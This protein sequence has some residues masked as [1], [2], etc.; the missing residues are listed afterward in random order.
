ML[1]QH[2]V[3]PSKNFHNHEFVSS[4]RI[5]Q[6]VRNEIA[7][8]VEVNPSLTASQL[9]CGQGLQYRPAAAD[10]SAAHQGDSMR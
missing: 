8:T 7:K 9:A 1:R 10:L 5:P 2:Q 3:G 4:H 6:K